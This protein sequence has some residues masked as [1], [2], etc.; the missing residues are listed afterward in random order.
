IFII[1]LGIATIF[2]QSPHMSFW[3]YY[4][5]KMGYIMWLHFFVFFL[6]LFF[7]LKNKRQ[8][9][10]IFYTIII[11]TTIA[12]L[13]G[14]MQI[15]GFDVFTWFEPAYRTHRIFS[16]LGQPNFFASWLLLTIPVVIGLSLLSSRYS[17]LSPRTLMRGDKK[18]VSF[19]AL[20]GVTKRERG[21]TR[22]GNNKESVF[23]HYFLRPLLVVLFFLSIVALVLTQSRG[24]WIGAFFGLFFFAI[25]FFWIKAYK[26]IAIFTF[27]VL[28]ISIGVLIYFNFYPLEFNPD[29]TYVERRAKTL[30]QLS[31][32]GERRLIT[33]E[34]SIDLIKREPL[35]GYGPEVQKL[36]FVKYY[37]P[38]SAALEAI[39]TYPD[40]AHN[41]ILDTLLISGALGLIS[42]LFFIGSIFY[43][44]LKYIFKGKFPSI[45]S[46]STQVPV[47]C[48]LTGIFAYLISLQFSF[49]VIPTAVY[50]WGYLAIILKIRSTKYEIRN[51]I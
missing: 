33:W 32:T 7:N 45:Q 15:S 39:N 1:I 19:R 16:T 23:K 42:Y 18:K 5:R 37:T 50:F 36:N 8:I 21:M 43:L 11:A 10:H 38:N 35:L 48:L 2:S 31:S 3:G 49:H 20:R 6:V 27:V 29:D 9:L 28:G 26:R 46:P 25:I 44:A 34:N 17:F 51:N 13:Y 4:F 47:L 14:F 41:D 24:G 30:T 22:E 40:R 12:V